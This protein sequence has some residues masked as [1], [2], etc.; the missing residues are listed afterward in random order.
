[1]GMANYFSNPGGFGGA[2][3]LEARPRVRVE[4]VFA[5]PKVAESRVSA[6]L[7]WPSMEAQQWRA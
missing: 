7:S 4:D 2:V 1:V 6:N 5:M 3:Y